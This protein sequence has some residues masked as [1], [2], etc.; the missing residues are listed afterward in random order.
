MVAC[1]RVLKRKKKKNTTGLGW[2]EAKNYGKM[3]SPKER[4]CFPFP[5]L[6]LSRLVWSGGGVANRELETPV[7]CQV[8]CSLNSPLSGHPNVAATHQI[9]NLCLWHRWSS[10][11]IRL[12]LSSYLGPKWPVYSKWF[13]LYETI[14]YLK[15]K[16]LQDPEQSSTLPV[17][18]HINLTLQ[19]IIYEWPRKVQSAWDSA[20]L[21]GTLHNPHWVVS[22]S[23]LLSLQLLCSNDPW[24]VLGIVR[25]DFY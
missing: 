14:M 13:I 8:W 23:L 21:F 22:K 20:H 17:D 15:N 10:S 5:S 16:P 7:L 18:L 4:W 9:I 11:E 3:C 2:A 19:P 24:K 6:A 1:R 12:A 25:R